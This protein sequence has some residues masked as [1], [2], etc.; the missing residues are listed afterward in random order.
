MKNI[1]KALR[2]LEPFI[3]SGEPITEI[4]HKDIAGEPRIV[5]KGNYRILA[6]CLSPENNEAEFTLPEK[7]GKLQSAFGFT[8]NQNGVW[9]FKG[10]AISADILNQG[11]LAAEK[12]RR[13]SNSGG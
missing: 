13:R 3:M 8:Q 4:R 12:K 7:N 2:S 1:S 5:G 6:I 9:K 11:E 10:Q